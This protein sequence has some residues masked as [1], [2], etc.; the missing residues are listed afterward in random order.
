MYYTVLNA[1]KLSKILDKSIKKGTYL[2]NYNSDTKIFTLTDLVTQ[3]VFTHDK[4]YFQ[5][6]M[7]FEHKFNI[8]DLVTTKDN[9]ISEILSFFDSFKHKVYILSDFTNAYEHELKHAKPFFSCIF[10]NVSH[11][12]TPDNER[13]KFDKKSKIINEDI[14]IKQ[15][16]ESTKHC[17]EV[18]VSSEQKKSDDDYH[19]WV[20]KPFL[21]LPSSLNINKL[22]E[23]FLESVMPCL[24]NSLSEYCKEQKTDTVEAIQKKID[25]YLSKYTFKGYTEGFKQE[26]K[27][28]LDEF[29]AF[30]AP[31]KTNEDYINEIID[32]QPVSPTN[33]LKEY[34][35]TKPSNR[36]ATKIPKVEYIQYEV[37]VKKSQYNIG[38]KV[39]IVKDLKEY[40]NFETSQEIVNL[41]GFE[42]EIVSLHESSYTALNYTLDINGRKFEH[43]TEE[44]LELVEKAKTNFVDVDKYSQ[45]YE[46]IDGVLL[47]DVV[48]PVNLLQSYKKD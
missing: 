8:G 21:T 36:Y 7:G 40:S 5:S 48:K 45:E 39:R 15:I 30:I 43:I 31:N 20:K 4:S 19:R 46:D 29:L 23:Q 38:D 18:P 3:E 44:Y 24:E 33:S 25:S 12:S 37:I 16:S 6:D 27:K 22:K 41:K 35:C 14:L 42:G 1:E 10:G 47:S 2:F 34:G 11:D 17:L 32:Y 26:V 28:S 13:G 9:L